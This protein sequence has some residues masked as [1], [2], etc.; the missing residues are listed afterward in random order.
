MTCHGPV[1]ASHPDRHRAGAAIALVVSALLAAG[2]PA[3][4]QEPA[5][6]PYGQPP[7]SDPSAQ[8]PAQDPYA[9]PAYAPATPAAPAPS[10]RQLF[11]ATLAAVATAGGSA[12]TVGLTQAITGG[13]T[14][15]FNRKLKVDP[16]AGAYPSVAQQ[17]YPG[18]TQAPAYPAPQTYPGQQAYPTPQAY[19]EQ[20]AYPPQPVYP[21]PQ[22]Y[23]ADG[24]APTYA[25]GAAAV[26]YYDTHSGAATA[27]DP[28]LAAAVAAA[29]GAEGLYAGL[30]FEVH[31]QQPGGATLAVDPASHVFRT[32]ERFIVYYRPTLPGRMQVYNVNP[33]GQQS[34][35]D[36]VQIA[37][38][39]LAQL[40]PYEFT[41][42][43]GDEQLK[44]V[45]EPCTTPALTS[46]TR[47]IVNVAPQGAGTGLG[48]AA[49]G[50][51]T[52]SARAPRTRD[53]RKVAVE[54]TTGF[55]LDPVSA[56][57][58]ASGR[59][60]AREVTIVFRHR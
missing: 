59:F 53:I 33:A 16:A 31:A 46:A 25:P 48:L 1:H 3:L 41:A 2:G 45:L 38:G 20:Q 4:A 55:A 47:D 40:G 57:E 54:G 29:A 26:Q 35:I 14:S 28:A 8:P 7:A 24:S 27:P 18:V 56:Q 34:L 21:S 12:L 60:E 50:P 19:P 9:Q 39:Q 22:P 44:L 30:A 6:Y 17:A 5:A 11:A 13:L 49:C 32:G 23:P 37:A 42:L 10:I 43:T 15:W 51:V 52:R 58:Q 36:S